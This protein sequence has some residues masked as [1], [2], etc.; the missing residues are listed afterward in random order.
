M[1]AARKKLTN[2]IT[3]TTELLPAIFIGRRLAAVEE[4]EQAGATDIP[5]GKITQWGGPKP[6]WHRFCVFLGHYF[7]PLT[8]NGSEIN[9]RL[10]NGFCGQGCVSFSQ[11]IE[12]IPPKTPIQRDQSKQAIRSCTY[13]W[14]PLYVYTLLV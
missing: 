11:F 14:R 8:D 5:N 9:L 2:A 1:A 7:F 3:F 10:Y 12:T 13:C 6:P 4:P